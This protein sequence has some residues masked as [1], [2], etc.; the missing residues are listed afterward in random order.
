MTLSVEEIERARRLF[1]PAPIL[2]SEEPQRFEIFSFSLRV[3]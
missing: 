1:G 3:L 2:T